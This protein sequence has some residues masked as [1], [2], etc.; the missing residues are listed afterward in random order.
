MRWSLTGGQRV[1]FIRNGGGNLSGG[2]LGFVW[3]MGGISGLV[4]QIK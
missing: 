1:S 4:D 2:G 3:A